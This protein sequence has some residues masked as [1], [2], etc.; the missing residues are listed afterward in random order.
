MGASLLSPGLSPHSVPCRAALHRGHHR[1]DPSG[2]GRL[3]LAKS[4]GK[5]RSADVVA[6]IVDAPVLCFELNPQCVQP[7]SGCRPERM[8][9]NPSP[10]A[11][12]EAHS[13]LNARRGEVHQA[14]AIREAL[15]AE[16]GQH[17][18]TALFHVCVLST[19]SSHEEPS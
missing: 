7:G 10:D 14:V 1:A 8:I 16:G 17:F 13:T 18:L 4:A 15:R 3:R 2:V 11:V 6:Q 12:A 9:V 5:G 19:M